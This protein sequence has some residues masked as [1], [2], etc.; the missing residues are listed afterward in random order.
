V[1]EVGEGA[2]AEE[3]MMLRSIGEEIDVNFIIYRGER[4]VN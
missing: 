3:T 2:R 4:R 1:V